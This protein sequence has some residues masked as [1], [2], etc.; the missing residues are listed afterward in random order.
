MTTMIRIFEER[1]MQMAMDEGWFD[2][3]S[4]LA[5]ARTLQQPVESAR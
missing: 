1:I 4:L 5:I 3:A 2:L